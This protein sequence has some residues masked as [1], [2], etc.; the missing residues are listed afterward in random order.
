MRKLINL[1]RRAR[2]WAILFGADV[3]VDAIHEELEIADHAPGARAYLLR[4]LVVARSK[5][6]VARAEYQATFAPGDRLTWLD[7]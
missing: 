2:A 7:A 3:T 5:R 4:K 1:L 6:A